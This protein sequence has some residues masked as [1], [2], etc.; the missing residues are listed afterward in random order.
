MGR[1]RKV[2]IAEDPRYKE[3]SKDQAEVYYEIFQQRYAKAEAEI[4]N[5]GY[6]TYWENAVGED[7]P[8]SLEEF[9]DAYYTERNDMLTENMERGA[10]DITT[11]GY[12][13][14]T[15]INVIDEVIDG[16]LYRFG[17]DSATRYSEIAFEEYGLEIT[18]EDFMFH[19]QE[20]EVF[21]ELVKQAQEREYLKLRKEGK[22]K[23]EAY[24][25]AR[26]NISQNIFG[27]I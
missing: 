26:L 19:T 15:P 18:K 5:E 8:I 20:A 1:R 24:R 10:F 2:D 3:I 7:G 14:P 25:G 12:K 22:N 9:R 16:M 27:S 17:K 21:W 13:E 11:G 4:H 6:K 23:K